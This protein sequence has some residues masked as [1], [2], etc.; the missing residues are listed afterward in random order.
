MSGKRFH[1]G[2]LL[3]L[4]L[5]L[6]MM[7]VF[8]GIATANSPLSSS[9]SF[10]VL[11]IGNS[12]SADAM[13]HLY[14][15]AKEAKAEQ[16]I[17]ANLYIGGA[18]LSTHR[19][20][21][22]G[23]LANYRYDKNTDGAWRSE[24]HRTLLYGLQDENWDVITLQQASGQSGVESSYSA[25]GDLQYLI[26]YVN[27]HKTNPQV[28]LV[29]HMTWAYQSTSTHTAFSTYGRDQMTM[30]KA[31]VAAV[32]KHIVTNT[33]FEMIIP[34]GT[35]VQNVR[36]SFIGDTLTRDGYHL[37]YNLGRYIAG[38]TW[39]H[40][41]TGWSIDD[42]SWVP[43]GTEIPSHFLPIIKEAVKAA[44]AT[45]FAVTS[46]TFDKNPQLQDELTLTDYELL[47]WQPVGCSHWNSNSSTPTRLSTRENSNLSNLCYFVSS[48]RMFT[49]EDIPIG[50]IIEVD[51]GYQYRPE[52]WVTLTKQTTRKSP[53][54]DSRVV[55]TE[56]WWG[57]Y[58][59]R[60]FN[61]SFIG[62]NTDISNI[63]EETAAKFRIWV[64]KK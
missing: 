24:N 56:E 14:Q 6:V 16:I 62:S 13:E 1:I 57:D 54:R 41:L 27:K 53:V 52:G 3:L 50:S 39:L 17:I 37:S 18:S 55:V 46:S 33:G 21:A 61:V 44:V 43:N 35:A 45:P 28:K 64:P 29:W 26:D 47:D 58:V 4:G 51:A 12:F 7:S 42:L 30:Y 63:V 10:K 20:N 11:A 59:Y 23:N 32:Q 49:R 15:I 34:T 38:L 31:I 40:A 8:G 60:A 9:K 25:V 22:Q 36:T 48:G 2:L 5:T 19:T